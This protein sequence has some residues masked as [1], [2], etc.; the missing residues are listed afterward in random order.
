MTKI[1]LP[2]VAVAGGTGKLGKHILNVLLSPR[3]RQ[4]FKTVKVLTRGGAFSELVELEQAGAS[5]TLYCSS[6]IAA[7][8]SGVDILV[9]AY[10]SPF[11]FNSLPSRV[12]KALI[13][14]V[15]QAGDFR[16]RSSMR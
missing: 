8:L 1:P 13:E 3:F 5:V 16:M 2:T 9:N 6:T 11:C 12:L 15:L 4:R 7:A 10:E 14:S